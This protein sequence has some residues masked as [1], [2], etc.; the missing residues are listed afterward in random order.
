M[1][2]LSFLEWFWSFANSKTRGPSLQGI[3]T[4]GILDAESHKGYHPGTIQDGV[5]EK[6]S[7]PFQGWNSKFVE[8]AAPCWFWKL[9]FFFRSFGPGLL[10]EVGFLQP[11][12]Q[13]LQRILAVLKISTNTKKTNPTC[14]IQSSFKTDICWVWPLPSNSGKQRFIGIP[15]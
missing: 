1:S 2:C 5:L 14:R 9:D 10:E 13:W 7:S 8:S 12:W 11:Q 4:R 6:D 15:Y 3:K